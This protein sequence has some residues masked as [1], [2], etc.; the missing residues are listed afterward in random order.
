M[1]TLSLNGRHIKK[2]TA[3]FFKPPLLTKKKPETNNTICLQIRN[4]L[5]LQKIITV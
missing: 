1:K 3:M 4:E 2:F 5:P